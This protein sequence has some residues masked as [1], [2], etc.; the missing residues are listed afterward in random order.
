MKYMK[1]LPL[2]LLLSP[3][4]LVAAVCVGEVHQKGPEGP[5]VG[6]VTNHSNET[7]AV[8]NVLGRI[9][10]ANGQAVSLTSARTCPS[11]LKP[12]QTGTFELSTRGRSVLTD[13]SLQLDI[14]DIPY[15]PVPEDLIRTNAGLTTRILDLDQQRGFALVELRNESPRTYVDLVVCANLRDADGDLVEVGSAVPYPLLLEAGETN[16]FPMFFNSMAIGEYEFFPEGSQH[17]SSRPAVS[18]G[19]DSF[20]LGGAKLIEYGGK[21]FLVVVG[22]VSNPLDADLHEIG[23]AAHAS[24]SWA[25]RVSGH[26][27]TSGCGNIL[28]A[29]GTAPVTFQIPIRSADQ[30][31]V[32]VIEGVGAFLDER[33][34]VK[35]EKPPIRLAGRSIRV[36]APMPTLDGQAQVR[37][38]SGTLQNATTSWMQVITSCLVLRDGENRVV[39]VATGGLSAYLEPGEV[40][41]LSQPV[42]QVGSSERAEVFAYTMLLDRPP[43][44]N[45]P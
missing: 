18:L 17:A 24:T 14:I 6:E 41:V 5:W 38:V 8:L 31:P 42:V 25:D 34:P 23:I 13:P 21:R 19:I 35:H 2:A 10:D 3:L 26:R 30:A 4:T 12:G 39:G 11:Q 1:C 44:I 37:E 36:G 43:E 27:P 45:P 15:T 7:I 28:P 16:T 9:T 32:P 20:E 40:V 29:N 22:E 33:P